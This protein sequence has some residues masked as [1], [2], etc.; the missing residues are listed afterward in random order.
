VF[1]NGLSLKAGGADVWG[2]SDQFRFAYQQLTGD[3]TIVAFVSNLRYADAWSK[4]GV[5]IRETMSANS[6]HA[7]MLI[8]GTQGLAF[9][10]RTTVG[11]SSSNTS[12]PFIADRIWLRLERRGSTLTGSYSYDAVNWATVGS[13]TIAMGSTIYAGVALSSRSGVAY[14][15]ADFT[16]LSLGGNSSPS[17]GPSLVQGNQ[18]PTVSLT[19]PTYGAT[20][21]AGTTIQLTATASDPDGIAGVDF[22]AGTYHIG[23]DSTSPYTA[24]L[25]TVPSGTYSLTAVA[26]DTT[27]AMTVSSETVISVTTSSQSWRAVFTPSSNQDSAVNHYV[28]EIFP[29][30][31]DPNTWSPVATLDLGLPPAVNGVC[32][33]SIVSL[34]SSLPPGAYFGTVTAIGS[35]GS[36]RSAPSATFTR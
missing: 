9:Q 2:S 12:G 11:A 30:G 10:R 18:A 21:A 33:V 13:D 19:S 4:A 15:T 25:Y 32:D 29:A 5:M 23:S 34:V 22:Y 36:A 31:A 3:G 20:F 26:R 1:S 7:F 14:A 35:G 8:S 27:G 6:K 16:N 28:L 24:T 17:G